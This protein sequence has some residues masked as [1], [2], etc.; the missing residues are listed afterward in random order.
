MKKLMMSIA[1]VAFLGAGASY[2][3][4]DKTGEKKSCAKS[5]KAACCK[6]DANAKCDKKA[7]NTVKKVEKTEEKAETKV[8]KTESKKPQ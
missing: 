2:A 3:C 7:E 8:A 1:L 4:G 5:E 6:K